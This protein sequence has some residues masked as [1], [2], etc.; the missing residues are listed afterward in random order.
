MLWSPP[1]PLPPWWGELDPQRP[2]LYVTLGSSGRVERLPLVVEVAAA[3]WVSG[4]GRDCRSIKGSKLGAVLRHVYVADYLPGHL[5]ARRAAL[6]VSNGGST[7]GYQ[8]LAEGRPVLGIAV[9]LDQ[10]LAMTAIQDAGAGLLLRPGTWRASRSP[11]RCERL[12]SEPSYTRAAGRLREEFGRW[13]APAAFAASSPR[14][15]HDALAQTRFRSISSLGC[16]SR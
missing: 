3:A 2:T 10:Y 16:G 4:A 1:V 14:R 13:N 9:N 7:T 5:A 6:V 12:V 8:A 15:P 11:A